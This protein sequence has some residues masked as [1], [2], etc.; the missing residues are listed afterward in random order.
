MPSLFYADHLAR[1]SS[2]SSVSWDSHEAFFPVTQV[3]ATIQLSRYGNDGAVQ[4][5]FA[6]AF[7]VSSETPMDLIA[8]VLVPRRESVVYLRT[9]HLKLRLQVQRAFAS[10]A[11]TIFDATPDAASQP[12]EVERELHV[13]VYD[14]DGYVVGTHKAVRLRGGDDF[15]DEAT[16]ERVLQTARAQSNT[17]LHVAPIDVGELPDGADFRIDTS[18]GRPMPLP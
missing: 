17:T 8:G 14:D 10:A 2:S 6:E 18:S 11:F 3:F 12:T 16:L 4:P 15:D 7:I 13:A 1:N 5:H 9:G